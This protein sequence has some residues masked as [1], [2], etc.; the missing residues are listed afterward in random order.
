MLI[1]ASFLDIASRFDA[2]T[3]K[4]LGVP[5]TFL[6]RED[7]PTASVVVLFRDGVAY[8]RE[9]Q[10]G[11]SHFIEHILFRGTERFPTLYQISR[12]AEGMGGRISAFSTRDMTSYWIKTPPGCH[13]RA[14]GLLE[15]LLCRPALR[16]E[17]IGKEREIIVQERHRERSNP[18]LYTS[19]LMEEILFSPHPLSRHPIGIDSVINTLDACI[20][21]S[22][23]QGCYHRNNVVVGAAGNL[24]EGFRDRLE[25]FIAALPPG[26]PPGRADFACRNDLSGS[27]RFHF[28]SPHQGQVFL[29]VGW[30]IA[31]ESPGDLYPWRALNA[32]LGSGYTSLLNRVLREE[33]NL[34][35]VCIPQ[36]NF[37]GDEGV[38]KV[39]MALD[40]AN[41]EK[42]VDL[43]QGIVDRVARGDLQEELLKEAV[44]KHASHLLFRLED[45]LETAKILTQHLQRDEAGISMKEYLE[46]IG[47]AGVEEVSALAARWLTAGSRKLL[48]MTGSKEALSPFPGIRVM[49]ETQ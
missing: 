25:R 13:D 38:Y 31:L 30:R 27:S 46:R 41:T 29:S 19:L 37:Y 26:V 3:E 9:D 18:S 44:I 4:I 34:T 47:R 28:P 20:L 36:M 21:Q 12:E 1:P 45:S 14:F 7:S 33:E 35:Y 48:L 8:E 17:F 49:E 24:G 42:A 6:H 11:I 16:G 5:C 2:R 15:E 32:L 40:P 23:L 43:I 22:H 39:N 10:W